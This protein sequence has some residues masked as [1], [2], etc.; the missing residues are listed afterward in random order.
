MTMAAQLAQAFLEGFEYDWQA[1]ARPDQLAPAGEWRNWFFLAGRGAGKTRA[2]AEWVRQNVCGSTP[3]AP[4]R[5][6]QVALVAE[7]AAD[8]RETMVGDGKAPGEGSGLL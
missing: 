6:K 2:A 5:Y 7:T 3:L 8:A 1:K 4:G